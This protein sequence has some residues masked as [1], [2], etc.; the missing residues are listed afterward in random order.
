MKR[1]DKLPRIAQEAGFARGVEAQGMKEPSELYKNTG[2]AIMLEEIPIFSELP[3]AD[4]EAIS[5]HARVKTVPK[6][7]IVITEGDEGNSLYIILNGKVKVYLSEEE[8]R[9]V[10][11][12]MQGPGEY[13]GELA[14]MDAGPRSASVMTLEQSQFSIIAKKDFQDCLSRNPEI[15]LRLI[16]AMA[17]RVRALSEAVRNLALHD[18]YERVSVLLRTMAT[19]RDGELRIEQKLT[20]Q[21]IANLVGASREMVG[22][23]MRELIVGGYIAVDNRSFT[24]RK[25]LPTHW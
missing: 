15:A 14:L 21:D 11:L 2:V 12:N 10:I 22:R 9:E 6:N 18:V 16:E 13:F 19:D 23:I 5:S 7:T 3:P 25:R 8:G 1:P 20:Y 4:L 24:L 17:R